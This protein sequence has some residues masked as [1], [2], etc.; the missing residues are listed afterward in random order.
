MS[1]VDNTGADASRFY[2]RTNATANATTV[3]STEVKN[4]V[5]A[6][7]FDPLQVTPVQQPWVQSQIREMQRPVRIET[8]APDK[9]A[10]NALDAALNAR[11]GTK[12]TLAPNPF[13]LIKRYTSAASSALN[14]TTLNVNALST[15]NTITV[16]NTVTVSNTT[17]V[18]SLVVNT[19]STMNTI[20]TNTI[21][22]AGATALNTVTV[23]GAATLSSGGVIATSN[24]LDFTKG[25]GAPGT[26]AGT[27]IRIYPTL[28]AAGVTDYSMGVDAGILW[29]NIPVGSYFTFNAGG[30]PV[31]LIDGA[32]G[33][34]T[35]NGFIN[36]R[37]AEVQPIPVDTTVTGVTSGTNTYNSIST[38][39][40]WNTSTTVQLMGNGRINSGSGSD[41]TGCRPYLQRSGV[42]YTTT[43]SFT[44]LPRATGDD[45]SYAFN[46]TTQATFTTVAGAQYIV[47]LEFDST[48]SDD[49]Y[50]CTV[51]GLTVFH[52][53]A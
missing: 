46:F 16:S 37:G 24:S 18:K 10:K 47:G 43:T 22:V 53:P 5:K 44:N 7:A 19:S 21:T 28:T 35:A 15:L 11:R 2:I 6:A 9:R 1:S 52:G 26:D 32:T 38:F 30:A 25:T 41:A 4:R 51:N 50:T 48:R 40:A 27:K 20:T 17:T 49:N 13:P 45:T 12:P 39:Y 42:K 14:A 31:C 34:V 23:S 36:A 3:T 33:F 29:F 8:Q